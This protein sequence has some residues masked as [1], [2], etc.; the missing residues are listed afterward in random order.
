MI[1]IFALA[2]CDVIR[3]F[4]P[5]VL[6]QPTALPTNT[7][8][9]TPT[10]QPGVVVQVKIRAPAN[11]PSGSSIVLNIPDRVGGLANKTYILTNSGNNIWT[12]TFNA[13]VGS[14][15]R[16]R[17][18]RISGGQAIGETLANGSLAGDRITL[19]GGSMNLEDSINGWA[20][21]PFIGDKGRISGIIKDASSNQGVAGLIVM[22]SGQQT[23]TGFDGEYNFYNVLANAPTPVT[24][25]APEGSFRAQ[26][27]NAAAPKDGVTQLNFSVNAARAVK[28]SFIVAL[29]IDSV[30]SAPIKLAANI[31]QMGDTFNSNPVGSTIA[32]QRMISLAPLPDGRWAAT[33]SLYEGIDLRYKYTLGGPNINAELGASGEPVARQI[34]LGPDDVIIQDQVITWKRSIDAPVNFS[35][36]VPDS[37]PSADTV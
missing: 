3:A 12:T 9:P 2:A 5:V 8:Y 14:L 16:Y 35:L 32:V 11:T 18:Q 7:P 19:I 33:L 4:A 17:F 27:K 25:F 10:P 23:T 21:T 13:T 6:P 1:L 34:V 30:K 29:P 20:D 22:A 36:G 31:L 24:V 28:V 37:T 15:L 26:T